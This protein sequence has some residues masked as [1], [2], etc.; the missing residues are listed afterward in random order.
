MEKKRL[1]ELVD[2]YDTGN[3]T[4]E[5]RGELLAFYDSVDFGD[6]VDL[7]DP[8]LVLRAENQY[9]I[10]MSKATGPQ[11]R[12][13][14]RRFWIPAAAV[15]AIALIFGLSRMLW[16]PKQQS[17]PIL[18]DVAI[19]GSNGA[20][21]TLA[22]G[23]QVIL[24][25]TGSSV[26][27]QQGSTKVVNANG[28][29]FYKPGSINTGSQAYNTLTTPKGRQYK[30]TLPDG[31]EVML[32]AA[33]SIRYP[34]SFTGTER[35]VQ[36]TGEVYFDVAPNANM[37][38]KVQAGNC[39]V[40]VIG[41]TFDLY[42]YTDEP[43][44]KTTLI[45]GA[46]RVENAHNSRLLKPGEQI[47]VGKNNASEVVKLSDAGE[48][49]AWTRGIIDF[50]SVDISTLMR[51]LSRWYNIEVKYEGSI[52]KG[53]ISGAAPRNTPLLEIIKALAANGIYCRLDGST[54]VVSP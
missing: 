48:A 10:L 27:V 14:V 15:A 47:R 37:P 35:I 39:T 30:L 1:K 3:I 23:K 11:R 43:V 20:I 28:Q 41:T 38:F 7:D 21:L 17:A 33:S 4:P 24:D 9:Q 5:E 16:I 50:S 54:L 36:A 13:I 31:T 18:A 51:Q 22:N 42:A 26:I 49:T 44:T 8:K 52:P 2:K 25:S 45:S 40:N 34:T 19:P 29:L 46:V 12:H 32:N 53:H 6:L